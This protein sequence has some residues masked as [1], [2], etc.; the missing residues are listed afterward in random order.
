MR[1]GSSYVWYAGY[2]SNLSQQRFLCYI[3]GGK[4]LFGMKENK[5]CSDKSLP[6]DNKPFIIPYSLYFALPNGR[7]QTENW[8]KGGVAFVSPGQDNAKTLCRMWK[9]TGEQYE[10]VKEQEGASWY[11][12]PIDLGEDNGIPIYTITNKALLSN[13]LLPSGNYLKTI[14]LGLKETYG[15]N[16][17][18]IA[19]YLIKKKGIRGLL[20][21]DRILQIVRDGT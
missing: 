1:K 6:I 2:G 15:Y 3:K 13:I 18:A 14:A 10:E 19:D 21:K 4:P 5:G 11:D 17:N 12:K 9:I 16:D 8:S 7:T 20:T